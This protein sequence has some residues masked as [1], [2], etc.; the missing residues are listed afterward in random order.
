MKKTITTH[1]GG[2]NCA[3]RAHNIREDYVTSKQEHIDPRLSKYNE[4]IIDIPPRKAYDEIFGNALKEYNE[5][6]S[7]PE[8][9]IADYYNHIRKDKKKNSIYEIIIQIGNKDDTGIDFE[10]TKTERKIIKEFIE[11]WNTRNPSLK[12]IGAYIHADESGGTLHAHL[13]YIP[14]ATGYKRGLKI[15]NGL[16]K[17][18]SAQGF[19]EKQGKETPQI[20]WERRENSELE[21]ICNSHGIEVHHP[22]AGTGIKHLDTFDYKTQ[23]RLE[24]E[25]SELQE[26]KTAIDDV[27]L[28]GKKQ[29]V[30]K[31]V[32]LSDEKWKSIR[33][34]IKSSRASKLEIKRREQHLVDW[35]KRIL[36]EYNT[37]L[38]QLNLEKQRIF[39]CDLELNYRKE[40][41]LKNEKEVQAWY[42]ENVKRENKINQK[43]KQLKKIEGIALSPEKFIYE[44]EL[45]K[46]SEE[47]STHKIKKLENDLKST[48]KLDKHLAATQELSRIRVQQENT[49][50]QFFVMKQKIKSLEN[51]KRILE[52]DNSEK[53]ET[54]ASQIKETKNQKELV[55]AVYD[56]HS[57]VMGA[58]R[59][60]DDGSLSPEKTRIINAVSDYIVKWAKIDGYDKI[61]TE[62]AKRCEISENIQEFINARTPKPTRGISR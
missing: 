61:A 49:Q 8:R 16:N 62:I 53:I 50:R 22:Q 41:I 45:L 58:V 52:S 27:D 3:N 17:A 20:Q 37:N 6:Q 29:L 35:E 34:E 10:T 30:G 28:I 25:L 18:L 11:K 39:N 13:N 42:D 26:I 7:R 48:V 59:T 47:D 1:N 51:E 12:L 2:Q 57:A 24:Q 19:S 46:R 32:I 23:K 14:V 60:L 21:A 4:Y 9:R 15:Q 5:N 54:I 44:Y 31:G 33:N 36:D 43:S 55:S 56:M 38:S 40:R